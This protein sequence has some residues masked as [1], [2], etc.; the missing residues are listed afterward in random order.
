MR[1]MLR[2]CDGK[3][4]F[5]GFLLLIVPLVLCSMAH[6]SEADACKLS[7]VLD[8]NFDSESISAGRIGPARWTAHTP[9]GGDFG[10]AW[11]TDPGPGGPFSVRDGI[12]SITATKGPDG[13]WRSGMIAA[14]DASGRGKGT[15]Y[16]YFEARMRLP[17]GPG[18]WPSFWLAALKPVNDGKD[19]NVEVDVIEY[20]GQFPDAYRTTMHIWYKDK[21]KSRGGDQVVNVPS[22]SLVSEF[23][24]YGVDISPKTI[25]F[26]LDGR[27]VWSY[28]TPV[29]LSG[30]LYPIVTNALGGGWSISNTP[31]PSSLS[32]DYVRVWSRG[33][34][35]GCAIG[36][37]Q[38]R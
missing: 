11:M 14:A 13:R 7:I 27:S 3:S 31:S 5:G 17:G 22:G 10:D 24:N 8:E 25:T 36:V 4:L 12:L 16:G 26:L 33:A 2:M 15:Q 19:G 35:D 20:Y 29:E 6:S 30:P 1:P 9:W 34:V 28:P 37:P 23:H 32:V 18:T 21:A 38:A